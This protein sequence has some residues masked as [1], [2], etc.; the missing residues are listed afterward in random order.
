MCQKLSTI[1]PYHSMKRNTK[2]T[3]PCFYPPPLPFLMGYHL[4]PF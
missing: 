2:S 4:P 3:P 1:K